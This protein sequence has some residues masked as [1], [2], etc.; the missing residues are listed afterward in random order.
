[1]KYGKWS[2]TIMTFCKDNKVCFKC[3]DRV[4][5]EGH[6]GCPHKLAKR[7]AWG[8]YSPLHGKDPNAMQVDEPQGKYSRKGNEQRARFTLPPPPGHTQEPAKDTNPYAPKRNKN[9]TPNKGAGSAWAR[10]KRFS[11]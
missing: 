2:P 11:G 5:S 1:M 3:R 9:W 4:H 8:D 10:K 6:E 7:Q